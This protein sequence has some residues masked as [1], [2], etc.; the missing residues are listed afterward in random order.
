MRENCTSG[1]VR[2]VPGNRHSYRRARSRCSRNS[3][4]S[5]ALR[6]RAYSVSN[7]ETTNGG[8]AMDAVSDKIGHGLT[9]RRFLGNMSALGAA[10]LLGVPR[11]ANAEPP[12]EITKIRL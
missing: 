10:W 7:D 3:V 8:C 12:P 6:G 4:L 5:P 11:K 9:R 1:T 2:G